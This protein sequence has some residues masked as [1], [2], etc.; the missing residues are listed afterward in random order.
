[1][2]TVRYS[3]FA[4][5]IIVLFG[6]GILGFR[7]FESI[8]TADAFHATVSAL[9]FSSDSSGY[10]QQGKL[11]NSALALASVAVIVWAFVN[12]H[13]HSGQPEQSA[14]D[15]FKLMPQDE[16]L[17]LQEVSAARKSA[18]AGKTKLA[19]LQQTGVLVM[20]VKSGKAFQLNIPFERRIGANS[21]MLVL[22][23]ESQ[24][25]NA[26]KARR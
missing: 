23:T 12:F 1:M 6:A 18:F 16:G 25:R 24:I 2:A 11:L 21:K 20:G 7:N 26:E 19:V 15:Y 22:G 17:V 14:A 13:R 8:A 3:L 9:T 5:M 4:F 10:S